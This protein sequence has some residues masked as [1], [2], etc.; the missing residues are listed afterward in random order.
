VTRLQAWLEPDGPRVTVAAGERATVTDPRLVRLLVGGPDAPRGSVQLDGREL[1]RRRPAD[2]AR[3]GLVVLVDAAVAPDV[4]V[5]DHLAA[6]VGVAAADRALADCP[7]LAGRGADRAGVL[8]GGER[9][10]LA[11]VRADLL[12]PRAV[13]LRDATTGLDDATCAWAAGLVAA[14]RERGAAVLDA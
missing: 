3:A 10:A 4:S 9:R 7:L 8:S 12:A 5:R 13:V 14:W 6:R 11:W 1:G 2:R